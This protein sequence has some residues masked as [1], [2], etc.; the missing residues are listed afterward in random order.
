MY[1]KLSYLNR[2]IKPL[3]NLLANSKQIAAKNSRQKAREQDK[4]V[5]GIHIFLLFLKNCAAQA[6][7]HERRVTYH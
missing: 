1:A 2:A 7:P 4:D 6:R 3:S 5:D